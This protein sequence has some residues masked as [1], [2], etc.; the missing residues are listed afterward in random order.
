MRKA[1][2]ELAE[3]EIFAWVKTSSHNGGPSRPHQLEVKN[4]KDGFSQQ[5]ESKGN[6]SSTCP[7]KE[8]ANLETLF[9]S[10]TMD[11]HHAS[12]VF[13]AVTQDLDYVRFEE[14]APTDDIAVEPTWEFFQLL[15]P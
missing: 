13:D 14:E 5:L 6:W 7:A 11:V 2:T 4:E 1:N 9:D 15:L 8:P 12:V 3:K 10:C